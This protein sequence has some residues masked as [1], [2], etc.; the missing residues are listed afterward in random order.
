M[1]TQ[2]EGEILD[3]AR[4][5]DGSFRL[6]VETS[7]ESA[8]KTYTVFFKTLTSADSPFA[9]PAGAI[10]ISLANSGT[11]N[12]T[13]K[14]NS[15]AAGAALRPVSAGGAGVLWRAQ[16]DGTLEAV[17]VTIPVGAEIDVSIVR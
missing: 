12:A 14:P 10:E 6:K 11:A 17:A 5:A 2:I 8:K 3:G 16:Q 13:V 15:S 9:I 7:A 4:Q 1:G